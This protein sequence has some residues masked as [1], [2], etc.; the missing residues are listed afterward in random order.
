MNKCLP[1]ESILYCG[2]IKRWSHNQRGYREAGG[3][4]CGAF[5]LILQD[6]WGWVGLG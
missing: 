6:Y 2:V 1:C 4:S 3:H 5:A